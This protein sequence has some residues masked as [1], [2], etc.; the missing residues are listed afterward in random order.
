MS[1][2][3]A[4]SNFNFQTIQD[5]ASGSRAF[6]P[7]TTDYVETLRWN[8]WNVG[9]PTVCP[10]MTSCDFGPPPLGTPA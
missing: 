3:M 1:Q 2:S 6:G 9:F 8:Y 7:N 10:T 4:D 5:I